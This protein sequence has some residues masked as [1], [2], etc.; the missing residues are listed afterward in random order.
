MGPRDI[1]AITRARFIYLRRESAAAA[2]AASRFMK[3][4]A[5]AE[6]ENLPPPAWIP[7]NVHRWVGVGVLMITI[8]LDY[9]DSDGLF[10]IYVY[11]AAVLFTAKNKFF[12]ST[13]CLFYG[14]ERSIVYR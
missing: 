4:A 13:K 3:D 2:A 6:E 9:S 12:N 14:R 10:N 1:C 5:A 11:G 8:K 7:K